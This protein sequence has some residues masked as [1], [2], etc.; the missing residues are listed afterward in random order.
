MKRILPG[1][2]AN[3]DWL[4]LGFTGH[5]PSIVDYFSNSVSMYVTS[6]GFYHWDY[7]PITNSGQIHLPTRA[8]EKPGMDSRSKRIMR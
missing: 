7:L 2:F 1:V 4:Q 8:Q 6:H 5:R 3:G